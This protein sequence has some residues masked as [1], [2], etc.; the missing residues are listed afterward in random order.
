MLK[1]EKLW[2]PK[3]KALATAYNAD[4]KAN[5]PEGSFL[6]V[7]RLI[8][9]YK[10]PQSDPKDRVSA[11]FI[12]ERLPNLTPFGADLLETT[13]GV[14]EQA[15]DPHLLEF[16]LWLLG[17]LVERVF[18]PSQF[19]YI[20]EKLGSIT[21]TQLAINPRS[22]DLI[23]DIL[24]KMEEKSKRLA[25]LEDT[26]KDKAQQLND[27]IDVSIA[28]MVE[29]AE[30][31]SR[32]A[33]SLDYA[34]AA[35]HKEEM[36]NRIREFQ[37]HNAQRDGDIKTLVAS[38]IEDVPE[39]C[40]QENICL[41]K[42]VSERA[43]REGLVRKVHCILRIQTKIFLIINYISERGTE[44]VSLEDIKAKTDYSDADIK[45]ILEQLVKEE[46]IPN[47]VLDKVQDEEEKES[48]GK[49]RK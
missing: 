3:A 17:T 48:Q 14:L 21:D 12:L 5:N 23:P 24:Q 47:L 46:I 44:N 25:S 29:E 6:Q 38:I 32:D 45:E 19:G 11:C 34:A 15:Q 39:F 7:Q 28:E 30:A 22:K 33:L 8:D 13:L 40:G 26:F 20:R 27:Q 10:D 42:W 16:T 35:S 4:V 36:E 41:A 2:T 49:G 18:A 43:N 37:S 9:L 1:I 31:I